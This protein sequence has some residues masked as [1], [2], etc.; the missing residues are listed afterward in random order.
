MG[1]ISQSTLFRARSQHQ[2]NNQTQQN[3]HQINH[4]ITLVTTVIKTTTIL[5]K[6]KKD[7]NI[8]VIQEQIV[9][10]REV[11]DQHREDIIMIMTKYNIKIDICKQI[12]N[13]LIKH[14]TFET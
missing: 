8:T 4:Q 10:T 6:V 12:V 9:N 14:S 2:I 11:G 13:T 5:P 3:I 1:I 7:T